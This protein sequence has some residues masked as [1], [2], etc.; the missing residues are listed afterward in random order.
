MFRILLV[1][2]D[3]SQRT[4]M[5]AALRADGYEVLGAES[6][7][8]ALEILD[9]AKVDMAICDVMMPGMDGFELTHELRGAYRDLPIMIVTAK[10][11]I[12]DKEVGFH[13]GTDD[14]MV[15]PLDLSEF[16]LRVRALFRRAKIQAE[17]QVAVGGVIANAADHT[18]R[19]GAERI[20]LP[21]KEFELL[22]MLMSYPDMILT[23]RQL[24][25]EIW[26][27]DCDTGERTVDVHVKRLR[28]KLSMIEDFRIVTVCGVG[29]SVEVTHA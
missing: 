2:D 6:A 19:Y 25:D 23:R 26:G 11:E 18:V 1:E 20:S 27:V 9:G 28:E 7:E 15:K 21:R 17:K 24:M 16:R 29:Y 8:R 10:S 3:E 14:Y 5:T 4:I 13:A 22:F 12:A